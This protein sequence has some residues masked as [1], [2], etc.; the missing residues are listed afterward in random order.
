MVHGLHSRRISRVRTVLAA[1]LAAVAAAACGGAG[2]DRSEDGDAVGR[3]E[4]SREVAFEI[5]DEADRIAAA[6]RLWPGFDPTTTPVAIHAGERTLLFRH[7]SPPEGFE[8]SDGH[9]G[10]RTYPGRHPAV[11]AN[12]TAEIGERIAATLLVDDP[13]R[14]V[15]TWAAVLLHELFHAYQR[16]RHPDWTA[17][18]AALFTYP[19]D[20]AGPLTLRRLE[21]E[22]LRRA[23]EAASAEDALCWAAAAL[24]LRDR[25]YAA[26]PSEAVAYERGIERIEGLAYYIEYRAA[27]DVVP[28]TEAYAERAGPADGT[29]DAGDEDAAVLPPEGF[30]PE[31]VRERGSRSGLAIALL[32]D[33][34]SSDW[35]RRLEGEPESSLDGLLADVMAERATAS[36][37]AC[38]FDASERERVRGD[39][40][41]AVAA[42][43]DRRAERLRAFDE[44][45]GWRIV[46]RASEEPL[47]PR[48]FDPVNV[49]I[50]D[51]ERVLH[52]RFL[53]LGNDAATIEVM[54]GTALTAAAGE[55]PL[56]D[57]VRSLLVTGLAAEPTVTRGDDGRTV[58][59]A[60]GVEVSFGEG[61]LL[62]D[63]RTVEVRLE[64]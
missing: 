53:R 62:R 42:L 40:E 51:A 39:A 21:T 5:V 9:P 11:V 47:M 10:V 50:L 12:T 23:A 30:A 60:E 6:E 17:N 44:R 32:L 8:E 1:A 29:H 58:V 52:T 24:E 55:H 14:P 22:A 16:E 18:P 45:D 4:R 27:G 46:V 19:V 34:L 28:G 61:E 49:E 2:A 38:G 15:R 25:R 54:G 63:G 43:L 20:G 13:D 7:P 26:L 48:G 3:A 37:P 57:G 31:A 33:R 56:F 35:R 41:R 59:Q 64:P 36:G